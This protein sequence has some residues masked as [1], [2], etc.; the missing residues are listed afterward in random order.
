MKLNKTLLCTILL[1]ASL[2]ISVVSIILVCVFG[3]N[4]KKISNGKSAYEIYR[5]TVDDG[6]IP[7]TED[8]WL[9][10][11]IGKN[12][13]GIKDV[14]LNED[15]LL[16][17][18][19]TDNSESEGIK[20]PC[21]GIPPE[22]DCEHEWGSYQLAPPTCVKEGANL[23]YCEKCNEFYIEK[24]SVDKN[25]HNIISEIFEPTCTEMGYTI[26]TCT[27]CGY[28]EKTEYKETLSHNFDSYVVNPTCEDD[29]Y[30]VYTCANCGYTYTE[31]ANEE[32][33]LFAK[34]HSGEDNPVIII[35]V[36]DGGNICE[37]GY[38]KEYVCRYCL[39]HVYKVEVVEGHGH[40]VIDGVVKVEPTD[41]TP[42]EL[43]G[44]CPTCGKYVTVVI[45][46]REKK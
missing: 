1:I 2:A 14:Y 12:G 17:F 32:N 13:V 34:G 45:P 5:D 43:Y 9:A 31:E 4:V 10:S 20:F 23:V 15:G 24:I 40:T 21:L 39:K 18:V 35:S 30:I 42:G 37:D 38:K 33:K 41:T 29:G 25:S 8:E 7:M 3:T 16:V 36:N 6:K 19:F 22:Q 28:K 26:Y 27:D 44:Y 11:L 46:M